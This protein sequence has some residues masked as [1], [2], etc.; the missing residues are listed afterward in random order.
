MCVHRWDKEPWQ[1][2]ALCSGAI[3]SPSV[4]WPRTQQASVTAVSKSLPVQLRK[5]Q[6]L[7]KAS[8]PLG[9][10]SILVNGKD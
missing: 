3:D 7:R 6:T 2:S 1:P 5:D 9:A 10:S 4:F 8:V